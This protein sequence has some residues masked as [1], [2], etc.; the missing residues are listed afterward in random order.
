ME[1]AKELDAVVNEIMAQVD[2][3]LERKIVQ[4]KINGLENDKES[5]CHSK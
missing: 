3:K 2:A 4:K 1:I 5:T